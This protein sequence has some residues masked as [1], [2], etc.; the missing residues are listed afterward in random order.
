MNINTYQDQN[1]DIRSL[2]KKRKSGAKTEFDC[3]LAFG[4]INKSIISVY[5]SVF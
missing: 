1:D 2:R 3:K 5:Y 4:F